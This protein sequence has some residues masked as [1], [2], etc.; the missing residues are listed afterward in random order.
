MH[1]KAAW[2]AAMK[3]GCFI[4]KPGKT[5]RINKMNKIDSSE[6]SENP[7]RNASDAGG[8]VHSVENNLRKSGPRDYNRREAS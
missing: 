1:G 2:G 4:V 5:D 8:S 3:Q 7:A 6:H